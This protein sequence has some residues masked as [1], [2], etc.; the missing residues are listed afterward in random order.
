M[1]NAKKIAFP[2]EE[3]GKLIY[4]ALHDP[5]RKTRYT[6]TPNRMM[7]WTL[8]M[9]ITDRMLDRMIGKTSAI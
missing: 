1:K 2:A 5:N 8:P 9:L 6:I 3:V 4:N 7:Y